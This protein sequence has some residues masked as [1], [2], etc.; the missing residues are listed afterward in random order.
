MRQVFMITGTQNVAS[1][2]G[3]EKAG[4]RRIGFIVRLLLPFLPFRMVLTLRAYRWPWPRIV[5]P[6]HPPGTP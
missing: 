2:R 6:D 3:I 1:R 4:L 5:T